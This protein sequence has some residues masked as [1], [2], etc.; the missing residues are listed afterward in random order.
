MKRIKSCPQGNCLNDRLGE[1]EELA[2]IRENS[3]L[4]VLEG[5][6]KEL[7]ELKKD[8]DELKVRLFARVLSLS[9]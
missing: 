9:F 7:D 1:L 4:H 5:M 6:A 3:T 2:W 8:R